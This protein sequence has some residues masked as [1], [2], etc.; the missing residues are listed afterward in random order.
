MVSK[1]A[2]VLFYHR[3]A[4]WVSAVNPVSGLNTKYCATNEPEEAEPAVL[5]KKT[6]QSSACEEEHSEVR[7]EAERIPMTVVNVQDAVRAKILVEHASSNGNKP[8]EQTE[9]TPTEPVE[10]DEDNTAIM[11][12][13][14]VDENDLD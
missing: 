8:R 7:E 2:Y 3:Q 1:Y 11:N 12:L 6:E 13:A 10:Q 9:I 4:A 5:A 14:D